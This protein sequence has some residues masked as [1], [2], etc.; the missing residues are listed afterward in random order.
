[1][2]E[3]PPESV[4][5][6]E[7]EVEAVIENLR[8]ANATW[9]PVERAVRVGDRLGLDVKAARG[10]QTLLDNQDVEFVLNPEG[11][12][13]APGFSEQLVGL[14]A[15]QERR[16]QLPPAEGSEGRQRSRPSSS[17]SCT[18]SRR[19]SCRSS[20]TSSRARPPRRRRWSSCGT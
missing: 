1:S 8:E 4:V 5:V 14:E 12:E 11:P 16:F 17:S 7:R 3:I 9:V 2:I 13:P 19:S 15:G 18:G 6:E 20:T 10:E